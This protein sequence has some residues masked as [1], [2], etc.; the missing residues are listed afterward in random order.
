MSKSIKQ[1]KNA[2]NS[3]KISESFERRTEAL[4]KEM[5][6]EENGTAL[7][8]MSDDFSSSEN[9]GCR[10]NKG[11]P[12]RNFSLSA[13]AVVAA[14]IIVF[15]VLNPIGNKE[16]AA[17]TAAAESEQTVLNEITD[18]ETESVYYYPE[19]DGFAEAVDG[20][21]FLVQDFDGGATEYTE[22]EEARDESAELSAPEKTDKTKAASGGA[23]AA[24]P[25]AQSMP[26]EDAPS[27]DIEMDAAETIIADGD[28]S[29][30][31]KFLY[32]VDVS[33]SDFEI[34]FFEEG[35]ESRTA[36]EDSDSSKQNIISAI[37]GVIYNSG[38][39]TSS[40][41]K[42]DVEFILGINDKTTGERTVTVYVTDNNA[43]IVTVHTSS[44]QIKT[45]Y[46]LPFKDYSEI[47]RMMFSYFGTE[48]DYEAFSALK[49]GK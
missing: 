20:G 16:I 36:M 1:Y 8:G 10:L 19:D 17:D 45:S 37:G 33:N 7:K 39:S 4:L 44:A 11:F 30:N 6:K 35:S 42:Y 26:T 31:I 32:D 3:I 13:A 14:G 47:E 21:E 38:I 9:D 24:A 25:S 15:F 43:V 22:E 29:P 41:I 23:D 18:E 46:M 27:D 12:K 40:E 48:S 34:I 28:E 49:S 5:N 2:M